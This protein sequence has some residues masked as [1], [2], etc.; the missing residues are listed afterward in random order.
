MLCPVRMNGG[1]E[2]NYRVKKVLNN[3]TVISEDD[4]RKE[5]IITGK[6]IGYGKYPGAYI[7]SGEVHNVYVSRSR[8]FIRRFESMVSDIPEACFLEA[9]QIR[10][11]AEH[12]LNRCLNDNIVLA[13]A[14]HIYFAVQQ[15]KS[16]QTRVALMNMEL[17]KIYSDE[18]AVGVKAAKMIEKDFSVRLSEGEASAI[19]F[20]IVNSEIGNTSNDA[21]VI[22]RSVEDIMEIVKGTLQMEEYTVDYSRFIVH[23]K[24]FLKRVLT[25]KCDNTD[26][27]G[28]LLLN[29][30]EEIF[31]GITECI[32]RIAEYMV[33]TFDYE[34]SEAERFY[35]LI[36]IARILQSRIK[37]N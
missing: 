24:F 14:D 13:L 28:Q 11:L 20:H 37:E 18:Y 25:R 26:D 29:P 9:E 21:F 7:D 31:T 5:I 2:V 35:L 33:K 36:H 27:F 23:L 16:D 30:R 1:D 3:N 22:A 32:S 6:G 34:I 4:D 19:T 17:R 15:Y 10:E 8:S 12:E